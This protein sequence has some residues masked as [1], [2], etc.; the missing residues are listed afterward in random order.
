MKITKEQLLFISALATTSLAWFSPAVASS[1]AHQGK[2]VVTSSVHK[3]ATHPYKKG[4]VVSFET[5]TAITSG[6]DKQNKHHKFTSTSS[7][8]TKTTTARCGIDCPCVKANTACA[9]GKALKKS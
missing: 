4:A 2:A 6:S 5:S 8:Q 7:K 3:Q 1:V 9:L